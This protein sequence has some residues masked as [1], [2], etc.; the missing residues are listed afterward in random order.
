[1]TPLMSPLAKSAH[2]PRISVTSCDI[3][4]AWV[5][6]DRC[7]RNNPDK[8]AFINHTCSLKALATDCGEAPAA[9]RAFC[10]R[11]ALAK[12]NRSRQPA[13]MAFLRAAAMPGEK[14]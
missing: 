14:D 8:C 7:T 2:S 4:I 11:A 5:A 3:V 1:M 10:I 9:A 6:R 13:F 12:A